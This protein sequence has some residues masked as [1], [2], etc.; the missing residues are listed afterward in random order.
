MK[1]VFLAYLAGI[2]TSSKNLIFA[3]PQMFL[4]Y[5]SGIETLIDW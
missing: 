2:E 5:L 3:I 1:A 4:A